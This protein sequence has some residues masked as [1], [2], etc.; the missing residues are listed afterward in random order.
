LLRL[1]Q[2]LR[3]TLNFNGMKIIFFN[4]LSI[5]F[6][7]AFLIGCI[8]SY[9]PPI[10]DDEVNFLVIDGFVNSKD[11][12]ARITLSRAVA[13]S[14]TGSVPPE[15][16]AQ[17]SIEDNDGNVYT[18]SE[19]GDGVYQQ[20]GLPILVSRQY[21]LHVKTADNHEYQSDFVTIKETPAIDSIHW[22]PSRTLP[23]ID[24]LINTHDDSKNTRYYQW[25][26]EETFEYEAPYNAYLKYENQEIVFIP[27]EEQTFRCWRVL[28]SQ[29]ILIGSSSQLNQDIIYNFPLSFI[30]KGSQKLT[31]KYSILVKQK[32]LSREAYDY[33]LNLQKTT[34][35]LGSLFDPQPG[36]VRGNI[37][38][39]HHSNEPVL[40]YFDVASAQEKR[41][42]LRASDLP[43]E[44]RS[45]KSFGNCKI[46][47][48]LVEDLP[49]FDSG[50]LLNPVYQMGP[51]PIGYTY[52]FFSC[53]DCQTQGG[54]IT[55]PA[56]WQ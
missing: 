15:L 20:S 55:K 27:Q 11:G 31:I 9:P 24:I 30:P 54:E 50:A 13:L 16:N 43:D 17:V 51:Q 3:T 28:P 33:W 32:A 23:G 4:R 25:S 5:L 40:G 36:R 46:D 1:F 2:Q 47:T 29:K 56:Y 45:F 35:N 38:S 52:T 18:L 10:I 39:V 48:V 49:N 41:F 19:T 21:K 42:F 44:L 22:K 53:A 34:E 6:C 14:S 7:F 8:E 26:F 37:R 12:N